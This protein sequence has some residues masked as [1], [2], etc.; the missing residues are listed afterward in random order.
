MERTDR[1][2]A[3]KRQNCTS[4]AE[5]CIGALGAKF[6]FAS[7]LAGARRAAAPPSGRERLRK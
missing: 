5:G 4:L 6:R 1:Q 3:E 7:M 2:F